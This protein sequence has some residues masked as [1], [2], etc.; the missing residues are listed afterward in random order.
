MRLSLEDAWA[1]R[2]RTSSVCPLCLSERVRPSRRQYE[3]LWFRVFPVR[4]AR[5]AACGAV[6]SIS[7][8]D[9]VGRPRP[10]T[11]DFDLPFRPSELEDSV[12]GAEIMAR[13]RGGGPAPRRPVWGGCP[14]C[15]SAAVRGMPAGSE[16]VWKRRF[17]VTD[18]YRCL[19]CNAGFKRISPIRSVVLAALLMSVLGVLSYLVMGTLDRKKTNSAS[20]TLPKNHVPPPPPPVF[21]KSLEFQPRLR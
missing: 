8:K 17:E 4:P 3:G 21:R 7:T 10:Q 19:E 1:G 5:C 14:V 11:F 9:A 20:P 16:G 12:R 15:G 18:G 6:F 2:R 13:S